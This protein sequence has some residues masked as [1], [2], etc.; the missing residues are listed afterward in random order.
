M[1]TYGKFI[2]KEGLEKKY[3]EA[4]KEKL[5]EIWKKAEDM[6]SKANALDASADSLHGNVQDAV[7]RK[8]GYKED[9]VHA[10]GLDEA[11]NNQI[12]EMEKQWSIMSASM[13][14]VKRSIKLPGFHNELNLCVNSKYGIKELKRYTGYSPF[15]WIN[16][17]RL[18]SYNESPFK[19]ENDRLIF[20]PYNRICWLDFSALDGIPQLDKEKVKMLSG[21]T[22]DIV[23]MIDSWLEFYGSKDKQFQK[24]L[25]LISKLSGG[26]RSIQDEW[27]DIIRRL[28]KLLIINDTIT[29]N[30]DSQIKKWAPVIKKW[31]GHNKNFVV[32][33]ELAK[34]ELKI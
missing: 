28:D 23:A 14:T 6:E 31:Q 7:R 13:V 15:R 25:D 18:A 2:S 22:W 29:G 3:D 34:S 27:P 5:L 1:N 33:N 12:K 24:D 9:D 19:I 16:V 26:Y 4:S 20:K 17:K 10:D 11:A 8:F 30:L 21:I 32:F